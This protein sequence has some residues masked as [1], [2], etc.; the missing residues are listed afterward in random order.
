MEKDRKQNSI[1]IAVTADLHLL[2]NR[3]HDTGEAFLRMHDN[4]DGKQM[5]NGTR[6][7]HQMLSDIRE[8]NPDALLIAGDLTLNGERASHEEITE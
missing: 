7:I 4:G 2:A 3:L 1:T 6:I 8:L 5:K